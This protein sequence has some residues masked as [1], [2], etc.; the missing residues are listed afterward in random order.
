MQYFKNILIRIIRLT[1]MYRIRGEKDD[2]IDIQPEMEGF[3]KYLA[4]VSFN[5][6]EGE[7]FMGMFAHRVDRMRPFFKLNERHLFIPYYSCIPNLHPPYLKFGSIRLN[8]KQPSKIKGRIINLNVPLRS[9]GSRYSF[10]N[11]TK[12][13]E[14]SSRDVGV[15][16]SGVRAP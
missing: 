11:C 1:K 10:S 8:T 15:V 7:L 5:K 16:F 13:R 6:S 4:A 2:L 12:I 9:Q 3:A 14:K